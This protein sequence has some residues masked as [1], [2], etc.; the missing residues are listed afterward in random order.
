MLKQFERDGF[1]LLKNVISEQEIIELRNYL[2]TACDSSAGSRNLCQNF[3]A[4]GGFFRS[5]TIRNIVTT[6]LGK[7]AQAVRSL[8]FDKTPNK[9]WPV[10]WH[11]D[12]TIAVKS[13]VDLPGY[14]CWTLKDAIP[15]TQPPAKVMEN[16]LAL[17]I[18][19]DTAGENSG[20]LRVC[21]GSHRLGI[22]AQEQLYQTIEN[23]GSLNVETEAGDILMMR[24]LLLHS[25]GRSQ[26]AHRRVIHIEYAKGSL[27]KPLRWH[28]PLNWPDA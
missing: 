26:A 8:Y 16:M 10:A 11:Q 18:H 21:P 27:D 5:D 1:L 7:E 15:H 12:K 6:Y 28:E 19:L 3:P 23:L 13:K 4:I 24:P 25:S 22:L 20:G 14:R 9:N 2:K 17:R